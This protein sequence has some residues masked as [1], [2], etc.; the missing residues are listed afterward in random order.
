MARDR[1][2]LQRLCYLKLP[3]STVVA[4]QELSVV[5][6]WQQLVQDLG[7]CLNRPLRQR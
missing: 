5:V 7:W 3:S 1:A 4:A 6:L 2:L